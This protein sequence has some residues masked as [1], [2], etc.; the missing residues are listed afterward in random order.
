MG[1]MLQN[2]MEWYGMAYFGEAGPPLWLFERN[3]SK[4]LDRGR[5]DLIYAAAPRAFE[6][7]AQ[8]RDR[9]QDCQG[10]GE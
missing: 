2:T 9:C 3:L 6:S 5:V 4:S 1:G 8:Y 10:E 7:I